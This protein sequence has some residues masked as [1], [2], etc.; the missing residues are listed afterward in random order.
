MA[1]RLDEDAEQIRRL[2]RREELE[3]LRQLL[4]QRRQL[5]DAHEEVVAQRDHH[6]QRLVAGTGGARQRVGVARPLVGVA[7][8]REELLELIDDEEDRGAG[9]V[10]AELGGE[11]V[12]VHLELGAELSV[13]E[14]LAVEARG[15]RVER[16]RARPH[17]DGAPGRRQRRDDA[18]ADERALAR[19][20]RTDDADERLHAQSVEESLHLAL[21]ADEERGVARRERRQA[22]VGRL[23]GRAR[24]VALVRLGG[25]EERRDALPGARVGEGEAVARRDQ[26]RRR[27]VA[28]LEEEELLVG[29]R[30]R[31]RD[32]HQRIEPDEERAVGV[33]ERDGP[34]GQGALRHDAGQR[35]PA[36]AAADAGPR[37]DAGGATDDE[38]HRF[39]EAHRD[40]QP[41]DERQRAAEELERPPLAGRTGG[42]LDREERGE[43]VGILQQVDELGDRVGVAVA[44]VR[45]RQAARELQPL[46]V[47]ERAPAQRAE[48]LPDVVALLAAVLRLEP[49]GERDQRD[50]AKPQ[51]GELVDRVER[52]VG[53]RRR[54]EVGDRLGERPRGAHEVRLAELVGYPGELARRAA[55]RSP[56]RLGERLRRREALARVLGERAP[57][58]LV[59]RPGVLGVERRHRRGRV[60]GGDRVERRAVEELAPGQRL[61]GEDAERVQVARRRDVAG[62]GPLLR[63]D[64]MRRADEAPG[65]GCVGARFFEERRDAEVEELGEERAGAREDH[66]VAGLD[67]AVHDPGLVR[68]VDDLGET[69]QERREALAAEPAVLDYE[70]VERHAAEEL[71]R[72]PEEPIGLGA[73]GVD[74]SGV[75]VV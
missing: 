50:E 72:D 9:G 75:R 44:T 31:P 59:E 57:Q 7:A 40:E 67:V 32:L 23:L 1:R 58:D 71:H 61:V 62:P 26:T 16:R 38:P 48:E 69:L 22:E 15:E 17:D 37:P 11:R 4:A 34:V 3:T 8:E 56:Q 33:G 36:A 20:R 13:A 35:L 55:H 54:V 2:G 6:A 65:R 25:R 12:G 73:E 46:G 39:E 41:L 14:R 27:V 74:V 24:P 47:G 66:H 19:P 60:G 29:E 52:L 5:L 30:Q 18:G 49:G 68:R 28:A 63:R 21:A 64:V 51:R 45:Q 42:R 10:A 53:V 70:D 43:R